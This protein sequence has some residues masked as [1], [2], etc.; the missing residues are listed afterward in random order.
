[1]FSDLRA[2]FSF[3]TILPFGYPEPDEN[4]K[5]GYSFAYYPL[6]G[7]A[8][9]ALLAL[10]A[11]L[12]IFPPNITAFLTLCVWVVLTGGLH[13]DGFADSCDGLF[14][15]TTPE[16]RLEIMKD[17]RAGAWAVIG[18]VLLLLGKFMLLQHVSPVLL[19][20]PPVMGRWG[21]VLVV[22]RF[23][24]ARASG[25][26]AFFREG[27]GTAQVVAA[28]ATAVIIGSALLLIDSR[29]LL[30]LIAAPLV[31]LGFGRWAAGRLNGGLTGDI[32]GAVCEL[33][34]FVCLLLL[35]SGQV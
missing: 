10:C 21:I 33:T 27:F 24:Y 7:L 8:I 20:L 35:A 12:Q 31:A 30:G 18:V 23:S 9:G 4:R 11:S 19:M 25:I 14:A 2:A 15:T 6:V 13:L 16:K 1:M 29:A 26:G 32:Y 5:P 34:E 17:P 22:E 3:L 28:T